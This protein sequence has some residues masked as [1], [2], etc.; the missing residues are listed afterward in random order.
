MSSLVGLLLPYLS[1]LLLYPMVLS[2]LPPFLPP[3]SC[4][5]LSPL[6]AVSFF[7]AILLILFFAIIYAVVVVNAGNVVVIIC[8]TCT[9]IDAADTIDVCCGV[10]LRPGCLS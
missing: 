10:R 8:G 7:L 9:G 2:L 6:V 3:L 1:L 5:L 4:Y